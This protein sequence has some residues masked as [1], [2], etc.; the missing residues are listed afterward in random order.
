MGLGVDGEVGAEADE[1]RDQLEIAAGRSEAGGGAPAS[2][3]SR[4]RYPLPPFSLTDMT[5]HRVLH[6]DCRPAGA[7]TAR[8]NAQQIAGEAHT[9]AQQD[10]INQ[11]ELKSLE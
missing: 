3:R 4:Y 2:G 8:S 9:N 1:V 6:S 7:G 5:G 10:Q 11:I